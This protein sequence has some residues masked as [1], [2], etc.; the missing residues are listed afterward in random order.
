MTKQNLSQECKGDFNIR[1]SVNVIHHINRIKEKNTRSSQ[2]TQKTFDKSQTPF[3]KQTKK[4]T[5]RDGN[6]HQTGN[7]RELPQYDRVCL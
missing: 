5:F 1:K 2:L 4:T 7:R 6:I 3:N